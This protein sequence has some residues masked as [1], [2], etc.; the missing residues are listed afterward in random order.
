MIEERGMGG[1]EG[2]VE[3]KGRPGGQGRMEGRGGE[4]RN[5]KWGEGGVEVKL[6]K[7]RGRGGRRETEHWGEEGEG[8]KGE[9]EHGKALTPV[10]P[11]SH[12][13]LPVHESTH[14]TR[15]NRPSGKSVSPKS[16]PSSV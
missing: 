7:Q 2:D 12:L 1:E 6:G 8:R 4:E 3:R 9:R 5:A 14:T 13:H 15:W 10:C 11:S 16:N